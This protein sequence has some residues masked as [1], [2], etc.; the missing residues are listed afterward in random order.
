MNKEQKT[1]TL[2]E[3]IKLQTQELVATKKLKIV[4]RVLEERQDNIRLLKKLE[5]EK[6]GNI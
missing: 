6:N 4:N 3:K 2:K 5:D 1:I